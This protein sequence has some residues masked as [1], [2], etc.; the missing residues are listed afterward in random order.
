[1]NVGR[2]EPA[3]KTPS[4]ETGPPKVFTPPPKTTLKIPTFHMI[5]PFHTVLSE[6]ASHCAFT[7][8]TL[9]FAKMMRGFF[10][11]Y[12]EYAN[13]GS[14]SE[15]EEKVV[16]LRRE[17]MEKFYPR[18]PTDFWGNHANVNTDG[19]RCFDARLRTA[20]AGRVRPGDIIGHPFGCAQQTL[21][22]DYPQA[23]HVETGIGYPDGPIGAVGRVY[24]SWAWAHRHMGKHGE[25]AHDYKYSWVIPN[26]FDLA[27]WPIGSGTAPGTIPYVLFMGRIIESKGI[28]VLVKIILSW[29]H[30]YGFDKLRFVIAG[31]GDWSTR[32]EIL[33]AHGK[34]VEY[35]GPVE[36]LRR[37]ELAGGAIATIMPTQFLEPFGG[38]G[39]EGLLCGTPLLASAW[40]AF[41]ETVRPGTNGYVCR[42]LGDWL[43]ALKNVLEGKLAPRAEIATAARGRYS[44][45]ACRLKYEKVFRAVL[46][47]RHGKGPDSLDPNL[48]EGP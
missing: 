11:T 22:R 28:D 3:A 13:E 34:S 46:E 42:T 20:L 29:C 40:G 48:W 41:T 38:S 10:P 45:E 12:I 35:L 39:V 4:P 17:E 26:Y 7:T 16:I 44:L 6:T 33:R 19:W 37:A 47:L 14:E 21:V 36:G 8:K 24:E 32:A 27:E 1:M 18:K 2:S 31:Q 5:A 9:R 43:Q 23:I 30:H 15:A 25:W